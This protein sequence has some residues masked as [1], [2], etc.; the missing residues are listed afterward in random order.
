MFTNS[1]ELITGILLVI[2]AATLIILERLY[3]YTPGLKFWRKGMFTDF[4][5]YG[6]VQSYLLKILILDLIVKPIDGHF[7][8]SDAKLIY[9]WPIWAQVGLFVITHDFYI[10]WFHRLQ[11]HSPLLWRTHEAHH[12]CEQIDWIAGARSHSV[13]ILINQT[14]EF[15]P[16]IF[17]GANYAV[18]M[19]IKALIS[20]L[21]GMYIHSNIN[22]QS[23][24]LQYVIN[25]PEMHQW[26][27]SDG[28]PEAYNKNFSTKFAFWDWMFGTAYLPKGKKA[29]RFGLDYYFPPDW[30]RQHLFAFRKFEPEVNDK[31]E[32]DAA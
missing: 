1:V 8:L 6:I 20:G 22:V 29:E 23:G 16:M 7:G 30:F 31:K 24:K 32:T 25:G 13:E 26:H 14:I 2:G 10:Y 17:L 19:P 18:V 9:D 3:P 4:V 15:A 12:S 27:H 5:M 28:N 11:H 21:W